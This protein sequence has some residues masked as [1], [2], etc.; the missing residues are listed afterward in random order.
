MPGIIIYVYI[1]FTCLYFIEKLLVLIIHTCNCHGNCWYILF[2]YLFY[3]HLF[4]VAMV[5]TYCSGTYCTYG[6]FALKLSVHICFG[7]W[8]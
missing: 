4:Y 6:K 1:V 3:I 8:K 2:R 7:I 5:G